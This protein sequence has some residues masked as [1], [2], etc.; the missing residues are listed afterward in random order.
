MQSLMF[1]FAG[2]QSAE[3]TPDLSELGQRIE[4]SAQLTGIEISLTQQGDLLNT[5]LNDVSYYISFAK[6]KEELKDW[7]TMAKDFELTIEKKPVT[8]Q[9][10]IKRYINL[11]DSN[12]N[13]YPDINFKLGEI[14]FEEM[15]K[16]PG[17]TIY[18][19]Q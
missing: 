5:S 18:A 13:P 17:I 7:Y 9:E 8:K 16:S 6:N 4:T 10:L 2:L 3:S 11:R 19:F 1:V 15:E 14:I 12:T